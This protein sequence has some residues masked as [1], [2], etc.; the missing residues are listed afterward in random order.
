MERVVHRLCARPA[1]LPLRTED[2]AMR[3]P[4][5]AGHAHDTNQIRDPAHLEPGR[6]AHRAARDHSHPPMARHQ[7]RPAS[8]TA[9]GVGVVVSCRIV[10]W[11]ASVAHGVRSGCGVARL[12]VSA[13]PRPSRRTHDTGAMSFSSARAVRQGH[14]GRERRG[15]PMGK[16]LGA[17]RPV[18]GGPSRLCAPQAPIPRCLADM[19]RI[20]RGG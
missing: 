9:T 1:A 16:H 2:L 5:L 3:S 10:W 17:M 13:I 7:C 18:T 8:I 20:G 14:G 19:V 15:P 11:R 4:R 6:R 12:Q